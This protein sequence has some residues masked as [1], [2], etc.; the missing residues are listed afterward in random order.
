MHQPCARWRAAQL[1]PPC[2]A[3]SLQALAP[4]A[5][6]PGPSAAGHAPRG[7]AAAGGGG[8]RADA[9]RRRAW[10][11]PAAHARGGGRARVHELAARGAAPA[12]AAPSCSQG[13]RVLRS[14]A[15]P[16]VQPRTTNPLPTL[17]APQPLPHPNPRCRALA[18]RTF[19]RALPRTCN[20]P[21]PA[22]P[23]GVPGVPHSC[24]PCPAH[25]MGQ[26]LPCWPPAGPGGGAPH[27]RGGRLRFVPR[28]LLRAQVHSGLEGLAG[29]GPAV[30]P[31]GGQVGSRGPC[32]GL[33]Q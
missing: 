20:G 10:R 12:G 5:G 15:G 25:A 30:P 32:G 18:C 13:P 26:P 8:Q 2:T 19:W 3:P 16:R 4:S 14:Q 27:P 29:I 7:R 1:A 23:Q 17:P 33:Y 9:A 21:A 6:R 24:L 31:G 11:P 28:H 22:P